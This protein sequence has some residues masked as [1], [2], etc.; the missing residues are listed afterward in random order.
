MCIATSLAGPVLVLQ[1]LSTDGDSFTIP[2]LRYCLCSFSNMA[3]LI[4]PVIFED[5][6]LPSVK[7]LGFCRLLFRTIDMLEYVIS[8]DELTLSVILGL[9]ISKAISDL[10]TMTYENQCLNWHQLRINVL[11]LSLLPQVLYYNSETSWASSIKTA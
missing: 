11:L 4:I 6:Q 1:I 9:P 10:F 3:D 5:I 2:V 8:W 7:V